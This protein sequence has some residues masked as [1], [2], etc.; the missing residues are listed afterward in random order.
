[1]QEDDWAALTELPG[2]VNHAG[3]EYHYGFAFSDLSERLTPG[4]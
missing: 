1:M 3:L 2:G 4:E